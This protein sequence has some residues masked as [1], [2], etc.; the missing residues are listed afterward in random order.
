MTVG[1]LTGELQF[2]AWEFRPVRPLN[3]DVRVNLLDEFI[4]G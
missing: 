3:L 2:I 4:T 1:D